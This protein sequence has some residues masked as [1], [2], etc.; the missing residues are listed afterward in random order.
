MDCYNKKGCV[1]CQN[2]RLCEGV[3]TI[4]LHCVTLLQVAELKVMGRP[5][6]LVI[7]LPRGPKLDAILHARR[8]LHPHE[9]VVPWPSIWNLKTK[10][11]LNKLVPPVRMETIQ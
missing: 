4:T 2:K 6:V 11:Q 5:M 7:V 1:T 9:V 3:I 8:M 10:Q